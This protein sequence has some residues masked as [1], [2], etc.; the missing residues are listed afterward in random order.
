M[1][2][3]VSIIIPTFN[4]AHV[5]GETLNSVLSQTYSNW[6]CIIVDDG[7]TDETFNLLA[8]YC[9]KD[10]RISYYL[11]PV[12]RLKGA[13]ACRNFGFEN[14]KGKYIQWLDSD[15]FLSENKLEEQVLLMKEDSSNLITSIWGRFTNPNKLITYSNYSSFNDFDNIR[16]FLNALAISKGYFPI[17][18]YLMSRDVVMKS[19]GWD[20]SLIVN[21]DGEFMSRIFK[22]VNKFYCAINTSVFYKQNDGNSTSIYSSIEKAEA[23]I[24][25]WRKISKRLKNESKSYVFNNKKLL[26]KN[27][28]ITYPGLVYKNLYF[29]VDVFL[30]NWYQT[31]L[32]RRLIIKI[33]KFFISK[34]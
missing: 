2:P 23:A 17:H 13:N 25:I 32:I 8:K 3:L 27:I 5:I 14:S 19:G 24:K 28:K 30:Y 31:S 6:E 10:S 1:Q 22:Y 11:R 29:F 26:Y 18:A 33:N 12:K 34:K 7:S 20:E 16:G 9:E 21:Q 4:R 15:D